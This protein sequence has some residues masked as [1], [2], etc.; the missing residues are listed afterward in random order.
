ME[1]NI[2]N[3]AMEVKYNLEQTI[4]NRVSVRDYHRN[5]LSKNDIVKIENLLKQEIQTP[6]N[7]KLRF[8]LI[9]KKEYA[10][11]DKLK[12]GTYGFVSGAEYFIVGVSEK[13]KEALVDYGYA[14]EKIILDI[15]A[16][17]FGTCWL[18][19]SFSREQFGKTIQIGNNEVIPAI[20][21]VGISKGHGLKSKI[22]RG[23]MGSKKRKNSQELFFENAFNNAYTSGSD[24]M[25]YALEMLRL[26]PSAENKQPWRLLFEN[27]SIH[28]YLKRNA[29]IKKVIKSADLQQV[30][31]GIAM[32]HFDCALKETKQNGNWH[33]SLSRFDIKESKLEYIV[34]WDFN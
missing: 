10:M 14:L 27:G 23:A 19:G 33:I 18:G 13:S 15:T 21:P 9:D 1:R 29:A 16:E 30:D 17:G 7:T 20:T 34:S 28:F 3:D 31:L 24:T 11:G 22:L 25:Q 5:A 6:F 32:C 26:A 8:K 2:N 12:L 4:K